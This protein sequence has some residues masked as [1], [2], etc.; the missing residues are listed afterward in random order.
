[1]PR[2]K[3]GAIPSYRHH[4][5]RN[6]AVVTIDGHDHYLGPFGS[7][8]SKQKY[9]SLIRAW[10][11]RQEQNE[12]A[13]DEL[14]VPNDHPT[15]NE[16]ILAYLKHARDYY[17]PNHGE[18]K[19]AGC[20]ND[21][22]TVLQVQ[23]YGR[24]PADAFRPKDLKKVREAM[25]AKNW[26][27]SYI[28]SQVNRVKRMFAY[29]VEEDLIPGTVYHALLTV[30]GLRKGT[31]G[32]REA[33]KIQPVLGEHIKAVLGKAH[34]VLKAML[35]FAYRTGARPGEVCA[36]KPCHLDRTGKVWV[37]NVPP[38]ANKTEH[39]D[40]ER[41]VYI[42]PKAKKIL[43]PWLEEIAPEEYVF[44]PIRAEQLRQKA[45]REARKTPLYPSHL[46]R[47]EAKR[48]LSPKRP[49]RDHYDPISFRR[50]VK[51]LCKSAK[52]PS[53]TP[54]RLRHNAATRFRKKY[55]IEI[56]RILLGHRKLNTTE[57]YA[58][59]NAQKA[60]RAALDLG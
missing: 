5:A 59:P 41:K 8:S 43:E 28:N 37:Y 34:A 42:G 12:V 4:K 58:E 21:A 38:D 18:N 7:P 9:A 16:V 13:T 51:R 25:T 52:V 53:W 24:E 10:Q 60:M 26:S 35:L 44:N 39:H 47:L 57:I 17:R 14:L 6:C 2:L 11:Q 22:L 1:M 36:L 48:K 31:P 27:R 46:K 20:I 19:E 40:Q 32:V 30:K 3:K 29:A 49:K 56:A 23:G 55:G 50:A 15:I 45:R 33:K 54:N